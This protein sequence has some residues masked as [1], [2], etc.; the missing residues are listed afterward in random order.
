M[1]Q[2]MPK[3]GP[4]PKP[5]SQIRKAIVSIRPTDAQKRAWVKASKSAKLSLNEWAI[6][7]LDAGTKENQE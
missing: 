1:I 4:K 2:S 5:K 6:R 3:P 7:L